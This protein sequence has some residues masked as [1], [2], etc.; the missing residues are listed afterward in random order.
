M[1]SGF[2]TISVAGSR[3]GEV[4]SSLWRTRM[5]SGTPEGISGRKVSEE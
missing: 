2:R 4:E 5:V 1:S 3:K